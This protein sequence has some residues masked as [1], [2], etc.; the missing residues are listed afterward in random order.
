M[1]GIF[2]GDIKNRTRFSCPGNRFH[3]DYMRWNFSCQGT[4]MNFWKNFKIF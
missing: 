4:E 3:V 2:N 1:G